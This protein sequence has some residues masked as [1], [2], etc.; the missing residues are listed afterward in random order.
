MAVVYLI[1]QDSSPCY[2]QRSILSSLVWHVRPFSIFPSPSLQSHV[3]LT[4]IFL[5]LDYPVL[6]CLSPNPVKFT[7]L[8]IC[9]NCFLTTFLSPHTP[10][11]YFLFPCFHCTMLCF[12]YSICTLRI[13]LVCFVLLQQNARGSV[14]YK[15][16]SLSSSQFWR[17]NSMVLASA[18]LWLWTHVDGTTMAGAC[19]EE[20]ILQDT[21]TEKQRKMQWVFKQGNS[22]T[23]SCGLR[24]SLLAVASGLS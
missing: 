4:H 19:T 7:N 18:W 13:R 24:F 17:F 12:H 15:K 8:Y 14:F 10:N 22:K 2:V 16:R 23:L 6:A 1:Q 20:I 11:S 9:V 5:F 21:R 3:L